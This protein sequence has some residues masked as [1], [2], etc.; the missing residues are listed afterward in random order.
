[1]KVI[2]ES[3][4]VLK[5]KKWRDVSLKDKFIILGLFSVI[6]GWYGFSR[7]SAGSQVLV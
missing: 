7:L 6:G 2:N 4:Q 3:L 5:T 1:M